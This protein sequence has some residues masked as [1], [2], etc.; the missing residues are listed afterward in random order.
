M[1][2][3][4]KKNMRVMVISSLTFCLGVFMI[5]MPLAANAA[6]FEIISTSQSISGDAYYAYPVFD[7]DG[8]Y[9][10][11]G[12]ASDSFGDGS[13]TPTYLYG[14]A[15]PSGPPPAEGSA[16]A[17]AY[18]SLSIGENGFSGAIGA[19]ATG[20]Q[21]MGA[22]GDAYAQSDLSIA[23]R[24]NELSKWQFSFYPLFGSYPYSVGMHLE[25]FGTGNTLFDTVDFYN[26][27][28][29]LSPLESYQL[30]MSGYAWGEQYCDAGLDAYASPAPEP[31]TML[32]FG[33]GLIGLAGL[34]RKFSN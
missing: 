33:L 16:H 28:L 4:L 18:S 8:N 5:M 23:F 30:V 13:S 24:V 2:E 6:L 29:T 15:D 11:M 27:E 25:Y 19:L 21:Y 10:G 7:D 14:S 9:I 26:C 3:S 20:R 22:Y 34:R 12:Y 31:A 32:L 1:K 17:D